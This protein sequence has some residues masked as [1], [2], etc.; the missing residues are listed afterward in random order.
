MAPRTPRPVGE[1][2]PH[3]FIQSFISLVKVSCSPDWPP[4]FTFKGIVS[5]CPGSSPFIPLSCLKSAALLEVSVSTLPRWFHGP[6]SR[7]EAENLLSLCKEGS[8]L[9][10]LSETRAQDCILS[11]R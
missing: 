1:L 8:Y 3:L 10:R 4:L 7:A 5:L 11:L 6:L 2:G 9:V